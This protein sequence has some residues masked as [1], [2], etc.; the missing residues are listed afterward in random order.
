MLTPQEQ[1]ELRDLRRRDERLMRL[2]RDETYPD[3]RAAL[4]T[5]HQPIVD[6]IEA[7]EAR[8]ARP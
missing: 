3:R 2:I 5:E 1:I 4:R 8:E 6:R 7:L